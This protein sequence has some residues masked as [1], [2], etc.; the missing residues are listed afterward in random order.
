MEIELRFIEKVLAST[1]DYWVIA[2][3]NTVN[4]YGHHERDPDDI[5]L[6]S[7]P[8]SIKKFQGRDVQ[9]LTIKEVEEIRD[10]Y[11]DTNIFLTGGYPPFQIGQR[12]SQ[13]HDGFPVES[14][15]TD[16]L[17]RALELGGHDLFDYEKLAKETV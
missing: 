15:T 5:V 1:H 8:I 17:K 6:V 9:S 16:F 4:R 3:T 13:F 11:I 7:F 2:K 10:S 14:K 12:F